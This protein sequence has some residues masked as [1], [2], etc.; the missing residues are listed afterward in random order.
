MRDVL[1]QK[2]KEKYQFIVIK[3][4]C[5]LQKHLRIGFTLSH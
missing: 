5:S 1:S 4:V 3:V 2:I